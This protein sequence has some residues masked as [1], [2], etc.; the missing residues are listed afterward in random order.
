MVI[1]GEKKI[2]QEGQIFDYTKGSRAL[3]NHIPHKNQ[4][5]KYTHL[6]ST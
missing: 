1:T 4:Y 3:N 2:K 6:S 5:F